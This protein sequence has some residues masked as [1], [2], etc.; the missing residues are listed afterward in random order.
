MDTKTAGR[1]LA[2]LGWLAAAAGPAA[3]GDDEEAERQA[4]LN[5][6]RA[7][8]ILAREEG[9]GRA[10][11]AAWR[12]DIKARLAEA[13]TEDLDAVDKRGYGLLPGPQ[14]LGDSAADLVYTPIAPCRVVD[15]RLA[16]GVLAAGSQR[17]FYVAG[18]LGFSG[19]GGNPAGCGVPLG[20]ATAAVINFVAVNPAGAGNLRAWAQG[21][22]V[23][24]ASI[25]NYAALGMNVANAVVVPLCDATTATCPTDV[26]VQADVSAA[27]LVA[28]VVGYFRN[29]VKAQYRTFTVSAIR[30]NVLAPLPATG[31]T[32]AVGAQVTVVAPVAGRVVLQARAIYNLSH[33]AGTFDQIQTAIGTSATDCSPALGW[34]DLT[35]VDDSEP[36]AIRNLTAQATR[37]VDVAAGTHIYY[38]NSRQTSGGGTDRIDHGLLVATFEP[39]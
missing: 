35:F 34:S 19:Q 26:T 12:A 20:P 17:S 18:T 13:S 25:I 14:A 28:D 21:G 38:L 1:L 4:A 24:N 30:S 39:N 3:A 32:N 23:P 27:H 10:F 29:V 15:T 7:E 5:A 33:V 37:I 9:R 11:E 2:V 36:T 31:C 22:A 8:A 16:G 6:A